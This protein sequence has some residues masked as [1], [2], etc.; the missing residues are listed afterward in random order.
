[1]DDIIRRMK[2]GVSTKTDCPETMDGSAFLALALEMS[3]SVSLD[4]MLINF[5]KHSNSYIGTNNKII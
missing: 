2:S 4:D 1:M 5:N 3:G